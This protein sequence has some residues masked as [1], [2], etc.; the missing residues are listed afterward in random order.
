VQT[1]FNNSGSMAR[2]VY[3]VGC[4]PKKVNPIYTTDL[5][6]VLDLEDLWNWLKCERAM[7]G[8]Y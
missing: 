8:C 7:S 2:R 1:L 4:F 3:N 6:S 5:P